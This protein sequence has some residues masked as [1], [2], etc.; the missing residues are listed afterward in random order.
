MPEVCLQVK[1]ESLKNDTE[2]RVHIQIA[3][4]W[5]LTKSKKELA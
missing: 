3:A 4:N 2:L 5:P 1:A